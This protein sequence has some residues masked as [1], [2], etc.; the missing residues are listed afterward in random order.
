MKLYRLSI[1]HEHTIKTE[2]AA[3][4]RQLKTFLSMCLLHHEKS[5]SVDLMTKANN[6]LVCHFDEV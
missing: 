2:N 1:A 6:K 4:S 3:V 5:A